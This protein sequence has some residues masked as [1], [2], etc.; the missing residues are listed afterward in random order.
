MLEDFTSLCVNLILEQRVW[1]PLFLQ[2]QQE[3]E[4]HDRLQQLMPLLSL[5]KEQLRRE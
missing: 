5:E 3:R 2:Q 1:R 4:R